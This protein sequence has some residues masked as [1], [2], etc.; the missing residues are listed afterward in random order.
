MKKILALLFAAVI[1]V[2]VCAC[3]SGGND[4]SSSSGSFSE[5]TDAEYGY[6]SLLNDRTFEKGFVVRGLGN[7]IYN[8]PVEF[9]GTD[10]FNPNVWFDY[11]KKDAKKPKWQLCQWA[12]RYPFHDKNNTTDSFNYRF[13]DEGNGKYLYEN[14]SKTVETNTKTGEFRLAL[15]A[16]ECYKYD[17]VQGQEWPHLLIAQ[18]WVYSETDLQYKVSESDSLKYRI[19]AKMNSFEDKM[20]GEADPSLHSAICV[21]YLYVA[22][23][24]EGAISY[25][26]MLWL[27]FP[28]FD[29]RTPYPTGMSFIDEGSKG[30]AT[31]KWI[32]NISSIDYLTP[33][34]NMFDKQGNIQTEKWVE[35]DLEMIPYI[36]R[37]LN[38]AQRGG[39]MK[40]ATMDTLYIS[41]MYVGFELPGTYDIDV[42]FK[43][44]QI[45]SYIK[46]K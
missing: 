32:Y 11:E 14:R 12:T 19:K 1:P 23:K 17:R 13:T 21:A 45:E 25:T 16:S 31:G 24:P 28:I 34:N 30:S 33:S 3:N 44:L 10:A 6:V 41:G 46:T 27:G 39:L 5:S 38:D 37:A 43:D 40:G 26:D 42:S 2:S 8:D 35:I 15:K 29:N 36:E 7:P 4:S 20:V 9:F 18:E 22:H